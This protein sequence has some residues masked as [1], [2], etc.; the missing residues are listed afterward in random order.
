MIAELM[1]QHRCAT[2]QE[3]VCDLEDNPFFAQHRPDLLYA[4]NVCRSRPIVGITDICDYQN[5]FCRIQIFK[6]LADR[7]PSFRILWEI[8]VD[9]PPKEI[10][11]SF[12][13]SLRTCNKSPR[14]HARQIW[15]LVSYRA[16]RTIFPLTEAQAKRFRINYSID[17]ETITPR[18]PKSQ[19]LY[20]DGWLANYIQ[21]KFY[22]PAM[23]MSQNKIS[24][25]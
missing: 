6:T 15:E 11:N 23:N 7:S 9:I 17:T 24:F 21:Q 10:G 3:V 22:S 18:A 1:L 14:H 19:I 8:K 2:A 5:D 20:I 13:A 16:P 25:K 4:F 12:S